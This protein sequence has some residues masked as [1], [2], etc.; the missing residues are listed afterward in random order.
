MNKI[1]KDEALFKRNVDRFVSAMQDPNTKHI[2]FENDDGTFKMIPIISF[3][4]T[5]DK[6]DFVNNLGK[7]KVEVSN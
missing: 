6:K 3:G 4:S 2:I 7:S 1:G 5:Q